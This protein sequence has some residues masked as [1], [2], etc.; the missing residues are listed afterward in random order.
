MKSIVSPGS[1]AKITKEVGFLPFFKN[2]IKGFSVEEMTPKK[3]WF[4]KDVEGPW[5]W[6][7]PAIESGDLVY[8]KI[9]NN[10]AGFL[11]VE[12]FGALCNWRRSYLQT[13]DSPESTA[14]AIYSALEDNIVLGTKELKDI[15]GFGPLKEFD[16]FR[17]VTNGGFESS[18]TKLQMAGQICI[19]NFTYNTTKEGKKYGWGIAEYTLPRYLFGE[20]AVRLP[21]ET[22]EDSL[23]RLL[24]HFKNSLARFGISAEDEDILYLLGTPRRKNSSKKINKAHS[25]SQFFC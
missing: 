21:H 19:Q 17:T 23:A 20:S 4:V 18:L 8:G 9:F 14:Y 22:P 25:F 12:L 16:S 6:K 11:R 13:D 7:G 2:R 3:Y 1:I 24:S 10:K 5:E 15:C